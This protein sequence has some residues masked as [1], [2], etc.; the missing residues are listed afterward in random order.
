MPNRDETN[1]SSVDTQTSAAGMHT[2]ERSVKGATADD[3]LELLSDE[4]TRRLLKALSVEARPARELMKVCDISRPTVYRRMNRLQ[5]HGLVST[6]TE[7]DPDGNHRKVFETKLEQATVNL[8]NGE[9]ALRLVIRD[10]GTQHESR[11]TTV[12]AD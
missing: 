11:P 5:E 6:D 1:A 2:R 10:D 9:P 7:L 12:S 8:R 4:Y 3:L